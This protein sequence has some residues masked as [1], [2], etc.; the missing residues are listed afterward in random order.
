MTL[1]RQD[2]QAI[3]STAQRLGVDPRTLGALFELE[4]GVNPNI[5]G[6][7]GGNYRGLIQFGPG[8]RKEVGLP[9]RQMSIPE[10]LPYVEKYFQ[11]RGFKPGKHGTT[12]LYRTVLVGNPGQSGTDSFGTNSDKAAK[13]MMPGGDLYQRFSKK[14][15]PVWDGGSASGNTGLTPPA[16]GAGLDDVLAALAPPSPAIRSDAPRTDDFLGAGVGPSSLAGA[17]FDGP[18]ERMA[19]TSLVAAIMGGAPI[20]GA[21]PPMAGLPAAQDLLAMNTSPSGASMGTSPMGQGGG[22]LKVGRIADPKEDVFPTTG[23]HLDARVVNNKGEYINPKTARSLLQNLVVGGKPL[24]S[25]SNGDWVSAYPVTS[26]FGPRAAP[27]AGASTFHRGVDYGV[28]A[29][30]PLEWR[31]GGSY[32]FKD[33][34][35]VIDLPSGYKIKLLHTRPS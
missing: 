31:G 26:G 24:Y 15:E 14:F 12:E 33:G 29:N 23:A 22:S 10:Q 17:V 32:Q 28:G 9:D 19:G 20:A 34:I 2:A 25:E 7:A 8:A 1:N 4:S 30:T 13:R 11:Q 6:G 5:W 21:K 27:T 3:A 16:A 35:G 18:R